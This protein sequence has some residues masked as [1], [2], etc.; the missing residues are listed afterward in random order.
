MNLDHYTQNGHSGKLDTYY[1]TGYHAVHNY[2]SGMM[3]GSFH[4]IFSTIL[5]SQTVPYAQHFW[6]LLE[7]EWYRRKRCPTAFRGI[8]LVNLNTKTGYLTKV[9]LDRVP[10]VKPLIIMMNCGADYI[11]L[12]FFQLYFLM[13]LR[14]LLPA[15]VVKIYM[16]WL[17]PCTTAFGKIRQVSQCKVTQVVNTDN[18]IL[19][20]LWG[21]IKW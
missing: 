1:Q 17:L 19:R 18:N 6:P 8:K 3:P 13:G 14:L 20:M 11:L 7:M 15:E 21:R 4:K 2:R 16:F 9:G 12:F 10:A 5:L